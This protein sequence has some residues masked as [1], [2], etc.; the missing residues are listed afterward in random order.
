MITIKRLHECRIDEIVQAWNS[1]FE[2][3]FVPINMNP[4]SF[5]TRMIM[6][7]LSLE[8]SIVAFDGQLPIGIV[9][10]GVRTINGKKIAWNGGTG[11][12][13][14]YRKKGIGKLLIEETIKIY[15]GQQV[16]LATLEAISENVKAISLYEKKGYKIVDW[17]GH[18]S[19]KGLIS[20][21]EVASN[22]P[23]MIKKGLPWD[24]SRLSFYQDISWQTQWQSVHD[25]ESI[26]LHNAEETPVAYAIFKRIWNENG[27]ESSIIV[28]QV[29]FNPAHYEE[30]VANYL[31]R[32]IFQTSEAVK[33]VINY[34][35]SNKAFVDYLKNIGFEERVEQ[36]YMI[37][38][39]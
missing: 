38:E 10:N 17:L 3:Y 9:V 39:M 2:G 29:G 20:F 7:G 32:E 36:V 6:E 5:F 4:Q 34:P 30:N 14:D 25:G 16:K 23:F 11:V 27:E 13:L 15:E 26:I 18:F 22:L 8:L 19:Q 24:A 12:A 35:L 33:N 21:E 28:Y 31:L 1:G 37:K